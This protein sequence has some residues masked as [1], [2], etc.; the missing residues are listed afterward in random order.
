MSGVSVCGKMNLL[1]IPLIVAIITVSGCVSNTNTTGS[2]NVINQT[3]NVTDFDQINLNGN[4]NII[5][6]QGNT[7]TLT[8][9]ADDNSQSNIQTSVDNGLLNISDSNNNENNNPIN[10]YVTVKD[11]KFIN[12]NGAGT[13]QCNQFS[14]DSLD[15]NINGAGTSN[16]NN[17]N[18]NT[19]LL[20]MNG[21]STFNIAGTANNQIVNINGPGKY[22]AN[23]LNSRT[24]SISLDSGTATVR[25]SDSLD[26]II[27]EAG[28]INYIGN[29]QINKQITG[30]GSLSQTQG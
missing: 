17:L 26:A 6:I 23:N 10:Y 27:K 1:L 19:L 5:L 25:V 3:K 30:S 15:I 14:T 24:A 22:Q 12:T 21:E 9:E 2:G 13:I 20:N 28:T 29:P 8:V 4:G 18:V 16:M 11:L 7:D